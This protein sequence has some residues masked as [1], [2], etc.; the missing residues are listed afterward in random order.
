MS[1]RALP[2]LGVPA[3]LFGLTFLYFY[4][5]HRLGWFVEDEGV[6]YYHYL[7][8]FQ[9]QVPYRD[10]F[11]G[12]GP[13]VYYLH[14][15]AFA[16]FGVSINTTRTLMAAVNAATAA[17]LYSVT[18]RLSGRGLALIP[19]VLFAAMQPGDILSLGCPAS[20]P[21]QLRVGNVPTFEGRV[22]RSDRTLMF[23]TT[24]RIDH[25][26]PVGIEHGGDPGYART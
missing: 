4:A 7:R 24:N 14:A 1:R 6:L 11:T 22:V 9:G 5:F 2:D 18:R 10:F 12:Y 16:L 19:P 21:I 8:V 23:T 17:G 13:I 3:A 20:T 26:N 15:A 25:R